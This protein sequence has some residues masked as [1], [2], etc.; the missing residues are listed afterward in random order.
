MQMKILGIDYGLRKVGLSL[1]ETPLAEPYKVIR[2]DSKKKLIGLIKNI[3]D[4]EKI[5][6]VVIGI[7]EGEMAEKTKQFAKDLQ[8]KTGIDVSFMDETLT[9]KEA[10]DLVR[11]A[12]KKRKKRKEF[13]DAYSAT[14]ILQKYLDNTKKAI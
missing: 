11:K 14:L 7:S 13:E 5:E 1:A 12:G 10:A 2:F 4:E 6:K 8:K 9:T 3:I